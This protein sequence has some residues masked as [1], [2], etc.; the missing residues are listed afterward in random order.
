METWVNPFTSLGLSFLT[1][2]KGKLFRTGSPG[3]R[4]WDSEVGQVSTPDLWRVKEA[5]LCRG[6]SWIGAQLE[7]RPQ[8]I[9][10][11]AGMDLVELSL[12]E[13]RQ[14]SLCNCSQIDRVWM[15]AS[16]GRDLTLTELS[17][18]NSPS[19]CGRGALVLRRAS[20]QCTPAFTTYTS[21]YIPRLGRKP[22]TTLNSKE[23]CLLKR[24]SSYEM[25]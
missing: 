3:S 13:E 7:Q 16:L 20:G 4:L 19:N 5:E 22:T 14:V 6:R 23:L 9:P 11:G 18:V 8:L 1:C 10:Q 12:T 17:A 2:R 15:Q 24:S 21:A 25:I